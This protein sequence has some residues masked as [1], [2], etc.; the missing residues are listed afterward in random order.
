MSRECERCERTERQ[1]LASKADLFHLCDEFPDGYFCAERDDGECFHYR[2]S[3]CNEA[4]AGDVPGFE[5][6]FAE[7]H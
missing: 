5:A 6:G 4:M 2:C 3:D 1:V 7:N